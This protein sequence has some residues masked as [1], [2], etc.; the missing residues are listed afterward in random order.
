MNPSDTSLQIKTIKVTRLFG[1]YD[2]LVE[3]KKDRVTVIHGPN[4]VGK[5][6][7]L[8]LTNAFLSGQYDEFLSIP[9]EL[10]EIHFVDGSLAFVEM[11]FSS[12]LSWKIEL[13][14]KLFDA[15]GQSVVMV[16]VGPKDAS[17]ERNSGNTGSFFSIKPV[18][19]VARPGGNKWVNR[20]PQGL[21]ELRSR[22]KIHFIE[23][24]RLIQWQSVSMDQWLRPS[25]PPQAMNTVTEYSRD[26]QGQ[27]ESALASYA[28][29]SQRL[30]QS[31]PQRLLNGTMQTFT[32]D[33]I[34]VKFQQVEQTRERLKKIGILDAEETVPE[35]HALQIAQLDAL[36]PE[37]VSVMAVYVSDT[38]EK[39][40]VL[41]ELAGR[42]EI[43]LNV[44][45][46][47]FI[48]KRVSISRESGL[49]IFGRD[50]QPIPLTALSSGEQHELVLLY[51][52]LFKVQPNTLV[53]ID[54]PE[55]SLHISWQK[56]FMDDLLDIIRLA[57]FDVLMATHSPYIV[58]EHTDLLVMLSPDP[59]N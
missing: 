2:H 11:Q 40:A 50:N 9:F 21:G 41:D 48:N 28:K 27:L 13:G 16:S 43:L 37:Q 5:T 33:Q 45:N 52:L 54:E 51:D 7:L 58:G 30:D 32:I 19:L 22:V 18:E 46:R 29:Q 57:R 8:R 59:V 24:Q 15:T 44:L 56:S 1:I 20:E 12:T 3:L 35:A 26:L 38:E 14:Y 4:G 53:L 42:V 25:D 55:L 49:A 31:F 36:K 17:V 34:K 10:F 23:A 47:K 39:L 6:A